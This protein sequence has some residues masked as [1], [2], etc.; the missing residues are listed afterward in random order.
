MK[1]QDAKTGLDGE[2]KHLNSTPPEGSK[3]SSVMTLEA[4]IENNP[5]PLRTVR[6]H[7]IA[8]L[9]IPPALDPVGQ[10]VMSMLF[11]CFEKQRSVKEGALGDLVFGF[12]ASGIPPEKTLTGLDAL[13]R[14]GYI[15]FQA[16]E[17]DN[18]Y[19]DFNSDN[20]LN[21]WVRYQPA[22][23]EMVYEEQL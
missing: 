10:F 4:T 17:P 14:S 12:E 1:I 15:K 5:Q 2:Y 11:A 7:R 16:P 3:A 13:R 6:P 21:A 8:C 9:R 23:L 19:V 22:F 18:T 20:V